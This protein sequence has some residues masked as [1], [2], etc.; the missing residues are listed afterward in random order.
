MRKA[1]ELLRLLFS[2]GLSNRQAAKLVKVSHNT[3]GR[4]RAL[5]DAQQLD[6]VALEAMSDQALQAFLY[7]KR[8]KTTSPQLEPN[9]PHVHQEMQRKGVT[10]MLLWHEYRASLPE[11]YSYQAFTE[12]YRLYRRRLGL[13]MRQTHKAGERL[14]VDYSGLTVPIVDAKT[15]NVYKAEIFI[16]VMGL[17]NFTY[18]E[19]TLTQSLPDWIASHVR[20]FAFLGAVP[21]LVVP[22]NLRSAV[23]KACQYDPVINPTYHELA[24]H[25]NVAIIPA[26]KRRPKDKAKVELGV[27][28]VQRWILA[29]LRNQV[30][31]SLT[32]LNAAIHELLIDLN[33]RP[34]KKQDGCRQ[35]VYQTMDLSAMRPLPEHHFELA[36]WR[37]ALRVGL[38]YHAVVDHH[39]YSLPYHLAHEKVEARLTA[40]VIEFFYNRQRVAT[41]ERSVI[42]GGHTTL[43]VHMP[44]AHQRYAHPDKERLLD[45]AA[46][47]GVSTI[48]VVQH[49]LQ[50]RH[51]EAGYR[52]C[53]GLQSL[54][55]TYG[56][57]RL[58]A[59]CQR[60]LAI[61]SPTLGSI[62]S[63]LK[64]KLDELPLPNPVA[65]QPA[66][67]SHD[68]VRGT[69]YYSGDSSC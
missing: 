36:E 24:L 17:S 58:E 4:F 7:P 66:I 10:L 23:N 57:V 45:W 2:L 19:A 54:T 11:G 12:Y 69:A 38:D 9:W 27:R 47:L 13:V 32:T 46:R 48:G 42:R 37:T 49:Q 63:I 5:V 68:N 64:N 43:V 34:F 15:G 56:E 60:A 3:A 33:T 8:C 31:Y 51:P 67:T 1:R 21:E 53:M 40:T 16:G 39:A 26:R 35:S 55:K 29:R 52:S 65:E 61:Q 25:Y 59:A 30:F 28:L 18:A 22:D 44:K 14:Y 20:M 6:W 50:R 41:H 62:H